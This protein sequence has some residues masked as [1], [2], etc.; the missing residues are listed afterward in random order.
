MA[1]KVVPTKANLLAV[2]GQLSFA[3]KGYELLDRKRTVLMREIMELNK[4]A[5]NLQAKIK[6]T[7][8]ISYESLKE[9]TISMGSEAL[10]DISQSVN[11]EEDYEIKNRSV[12]GVEIPEIEYRE[13]EIKTEYSFHN[14]TI[15]L[16]KA[17]INM[18]NLLPLIYELAEVESSCIRLAEEIKKTVKR[19]NALEK[20]QIPRF[21]TIIASI[22]N[23]LGEK[24]REDFF[25]M[26]KVKN[27]KNRR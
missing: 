3:Q 10:A 7:F 21:E 22:E 4:R 11:L 8:N 14:S 13:K 27:K 16:D 20:I 18:K 26:K 17:T 12:M 24:E 19:A 2:K 9:A 6:E 1:S 15:S 25:R 5:E 23:T